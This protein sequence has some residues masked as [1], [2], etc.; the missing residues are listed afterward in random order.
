MVEYAARQAFEVVGIE[1]PVGGFEEQ[2][3]TAGDLHCTSAPPVQGNTRFH[4]TI[5]NY[6]AVCNTQSRQTHH[7]SSLHITTRAERYP[8]AMRTS[9]HVLKGFSFCI[10]DRVYTRYTSWAYQVKKDKPSRHE[11][12]SAWQQ[13]ITPPQTTTSR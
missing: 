6:S 4:D 9:L 13:C 5:P 7:P 2:S 12:W 11:G 10:L 3:E 1:V 8:A